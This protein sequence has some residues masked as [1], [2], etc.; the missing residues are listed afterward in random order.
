MF[1][2]TSK[3]L[4]TLA[5]TVLLSSCLSDFH[6]RGTQGTA[7]F[8]YQTL[9]ILDE[10]NGKISQNLKNIMRHQITLVTPPNPAQVTVEIG[11]V[12]HNKSISVKDV[13]G[14]ASEYRLYNSVTIQAYNT[15]KQQLIMPVTLSQSRTLSTG[16]GYETGLDLEETRIYS[17]MD[18]E[19]ANQ[20]QYRLRAIQIKP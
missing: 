9:T 18:L 5:F 15:N 2:Q 11:K 19:L 6:L 10:F 20:I 8:S 13:N 17:D 3:R 14:R 4:I 16:N 12:T 7:L 1:K